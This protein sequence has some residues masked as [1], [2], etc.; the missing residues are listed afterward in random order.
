MHLPFRIMLL[1]CVDLPK[2]PGEPPASSQALYLEKS[3]DMGWSKKTTLHHVKRED[4]PHVVNPLKV[5]AAEG[6]GQT[7][8]MHCSLCC[9]EHI[10]NL[11]LNLHSPGCQHLWRSLWGCNVCILG[12]TRLS[13][14]G[15]LVLQS[16]QLHDLVL[17]LL[18]GVCNCFP[19]LHCGVHY[20]ILQDGSHIV[21]DRL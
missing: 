16:T 10:C 12:L 19:C 20:N 14:Q 17:H 21:V 5:V 7:H 11:L 15:K 2:W 18:V 3:Q 1:M 9:L 8:A 4:A 6:P 13:V